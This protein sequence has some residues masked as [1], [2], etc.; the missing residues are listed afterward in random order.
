M[1]DTTPPCP[2]RFCVVIYIPGIRA[3][4]GVRLMVRGNAWRLAYARILEAQVHVDG[5][6]PK[7]SDIDLVSQLP[8]KSLEEGAIRCERSEILA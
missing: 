3:H 2:N 6:V 8:W 7:C 5:T 1:A 4:L